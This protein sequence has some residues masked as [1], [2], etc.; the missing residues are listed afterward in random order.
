MIVFTQEQHNN[1]LQCFGESFVNKLPTK[2]EF[3]AKQ[4]E[5]SDFSLIEYYS[6]N[7]LFYCQ[8]EEYGDCVL[9]VFGCDYHWYI[10]E[11]NVLNEFKGNR[12]YV[13]AHECNKELGALLLERIS[14]GETLKA[15]ASI[16]KR[17]SVFS[18]TWNKAH[19]IPHELEI[20]K[21]YLETVVIAAGQPWAI[22]D[23]P[24]LRRMAGDMVISCRELYLKYPERFLLHADLHG[25]N[26]LKSN[27]G[28][29]IIVDPHGRIGPPICDLGRFIANE[30]ADADEYSKAQ[31]VD[32]I[33]NNL[34]K[35]FQLDKN[36]I[37][38]AFFVDFT[39]MTCWDAEDGSVNL[40]GALFA[41][42]LLQH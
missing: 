17:L 24:V 16:D 25:D 12:R 19:I 22:G 13:Q 35:A 4:W 39:L 31:T 6:V 36:D 32:Y 27:N 30:Y 29:Y 8:S 2:L 20:Y 14:P 41:Q 15:E 10:D 7:C 42:S 3:F 1:M 40:D 18:E 28:D 9:K 23:N 5:L 37:Q 11:I 33:I 26:L 38:K 34:S 21:S